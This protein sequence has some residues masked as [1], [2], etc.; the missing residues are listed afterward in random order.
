MQIYQ[1][2]RLVTYWMESTWGIMCITPSSPTATISP[3]VKSVSVYCGVPAVNCNNIMRMGTKCA[4][5]L[6]Q[7][8]FD[9]VVM[10]QGWNWTEYDL[11]PDS[12][13]GM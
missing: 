4:L 3:P 12:F 5:I 8:Y 11:M 1:Y 7:Y 13:Y 10:P 6:R 2:T 9:V